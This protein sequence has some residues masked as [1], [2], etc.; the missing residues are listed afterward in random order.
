[1]GEK[2]NLSD[3][4][5]PPEKGIDLLSSED[6]TVGEA[7]LRLCLQPERFTDLELTCLWE[8]CAHIHGFFSVSTFVNFVNTH[9]I[10][11]KEEFK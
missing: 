9:L 3:R 2:V 10:K 11:E 7:L 6:A 1:M 4:C 5:L 8:I